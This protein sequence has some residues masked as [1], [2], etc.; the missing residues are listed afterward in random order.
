MKNKLISIAVIYLL[1]FIL[2]LAANIQLLLSF[3]VILLTLMSIIIIFTQPAWSIRESR[4]Q[5]DKDQNSIW[6]IALGGILC[7]IFSVSE[8]VYFRRAFHEFRFDTLT[9]IGL[10]LIVGGMIFR[11]WCIYTLG[12]FFTSTVQTQTKHQIITTGAYSY[13]RH[14]SYL[15]AYLSI[16][17]SSFFLHAYIGIL[18]SALIMFGVYYYRIKVEEAALV[19]EFGE[20]YRN[21]QKLTKRLFPF[22]Y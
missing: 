11:I 7:Q 17:G 12:K 6:I 9:S 20:Q 18:F 19:R 22:I 3:Q 5:K 10:F 14:P 4:E 15:G 16:I 21:Y 13:L 2:P 1:S 8:W